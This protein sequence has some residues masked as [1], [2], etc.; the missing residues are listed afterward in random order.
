MTVDKAKTASER[1]QW[2]QAA[3]Q[4]MLDYQEMYRE[5]LDAR[6]AVRSLAGALDGMI[7]GNRECDVTAIS[8]LADPVVKRIVEGG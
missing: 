4:N 3:E 7:A 5:C 8:A 6:E 2:K 1:D